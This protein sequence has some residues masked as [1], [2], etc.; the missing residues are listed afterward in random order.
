VL[1]IHAFFGL[2]IRARPADVISS[3]KNLH[4]GFR[5]SLQDITEVF[6]K[7]GAIAFAVK[8]VQAYQMMPSQ[9][10]DTGHA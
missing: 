1:V 3:L 2:Q 4:P 6:N 9:L 8:K 5:C 10:R 7:P